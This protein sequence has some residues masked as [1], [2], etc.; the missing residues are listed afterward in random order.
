MPIKVRH[1][2]L[3]VK[4]TATGQLLATFDPYTG[5]FHCELCG[6]N[7]HVMLQTGGKIPRGARICPHCHYNDAE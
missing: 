6:G 5:G 2:G 4:S 7:W 3:K 1:R